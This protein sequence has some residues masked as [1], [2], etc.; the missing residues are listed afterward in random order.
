MS[1]NGQEKTTQPEPFLYEIPSDRVVFL[2]IFQ[3]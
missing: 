3:F 1:K 2:A